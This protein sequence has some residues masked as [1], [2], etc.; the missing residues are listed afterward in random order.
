MWKYK[1]QNQKEH[2]FNIT[3]RDI[4]VEHCPDIKSSIEI[5]AG[6]AQLSK[7]IKDKI[8]NID[9]TMV[10]NSQ[11]ACI[12]IRD[13]FWDIGYPF[14]IEF[15]DVFILKPKREYDMSMSSGL[16]EHFHG[17]KLKE[18]INIHK[19][20]SRK[21]LCLIVPHSCPYEIEFAKSEKCKRL[22]GFQRPFTESG[23]DDIV[24]DSEWKKHYNEV[25]YNDRLLL[26]IY[27]REK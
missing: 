24:L 1:Y 3:A 19:K 8:C 15:A 18:L 17:D 22:Y 21:Y 16:I 4:I 9:V 2:G 14:D 25:Y 11:S 27:R 13:Y 20:Y 10:E 23:L 5:G 7:L 6:T 26:S 12:Y